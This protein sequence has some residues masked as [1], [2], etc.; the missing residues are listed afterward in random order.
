M[1]TPRDSTTNLVLKGALDRVLDHAR[2]LADIDEDEEGKKASW[3]SYY[4]TLQQVAQQLSGITAAI[5]D[6]DQ[7]VEVIAEQED[8]DV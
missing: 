8:D 5:R 2:K 7:L 6:Y 4:S 3:K 1:T